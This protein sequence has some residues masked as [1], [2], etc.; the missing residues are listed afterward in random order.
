MGIN[1]V[2]EARAS[3]HRQSENPPWFFYVA[4]LLQVFADYE[5]LL[6]SENYVTKRQS[7]KVWS[8]SSNIYITNQFDRHVV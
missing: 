8:T 7:L 6:N 2:S 5:K 3:L 4:V 1:L